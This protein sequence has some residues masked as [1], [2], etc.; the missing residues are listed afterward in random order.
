MKIDLTLLRKGLSMGAIIS[1]YLWA[2]YYFGHDD[3][4]LKKEVATLKLDIWRVKKDLE[5]EIQC[6]KNINETLNIKLK[7]LSK[8]N[9]TV[10]A[11]HTHF[12]WHRTK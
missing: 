8:E 4:N 5:Y 12:S 6:L 9:E 2:A 7:T 3:E 11:G 10:P 1:Y